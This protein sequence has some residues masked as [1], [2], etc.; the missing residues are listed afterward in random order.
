LAQW[1]GVF[2]GSALG[3]MDGERSSNSRS[4]SICV[5][6]LVG[7]SGSGFSDASNLSP[8]SRTMARLCAWS[9]SMRSGITKPRSGKKAPAAKPQRPT[10]PQPSRLEAP[11]ATLK[12]TGDRRFWLS[13]RALALRK[14]GR[15][16]RPLAIRDMRRINTGERR[17]HIFKA[18]GRFSFPCSPI[19]TRCSMRTRNPECARRCI[20]SDITLT[21]HLIVDCQLSALANAIISPMTTRVSTPATATPRQ[22]SPM[23]RS[24]CNLA[25]LLRMALL[26]RDCLMPNES[27]AR[28]TIVSVPR[29][30]SEAVLPRLL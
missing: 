20:Q 4:R 13:A 18:C 10:P 9:M 25:C 29:H 19:A 17:S 11:R 7:S 23:M 1:R 27:C 6:N 28:R 16:Q 15:W 24:G 12:G 21:V 30:K 14:A 2:Q 3:T 8:I 5:L 26:S 22:S